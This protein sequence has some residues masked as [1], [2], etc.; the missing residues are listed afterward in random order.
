VAAAAIQIASEL[1]R[2]RGE[3][4]RAGLGR[5]DRPRPEPVG[6]AEPSRPVGPA[7]HLGQTGLG[8]LF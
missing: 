6:L 1:E 3:R 2:E 4:V 7:G 8:K 5:F